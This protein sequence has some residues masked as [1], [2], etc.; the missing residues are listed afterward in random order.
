MISSVPVLC[1]SG[2]SDYSLLDCGHFRKLERF[3]NQVLI[4]PEPQAVWNPRWSEKDWKSNAHG[5]F[6]Q[7]SS[8][9]GEWASIKTLKE[10]WNIGYPLAHGKVTFRLALTGFKHVGIFPE[11]KV[12]WDFIF[13]NFYGKPSTFLNLFAYTGGASIVAKAAG[14]D[15]THVD[16]VRQVVS[17]ANENM[18]LS[19]LDDIRWTVE[20]ALKF[21]KREVRRGKKYTGIILD[22]PS[23]GIGAKGERWKLEDQINE[24][25]AETAIILEE[26][27]PIYILN[28]YSLGFSPLI[29]KNMMD[30]HFPSTPFQVAEIAQSAESGITLPLGV[31]AR[32]G[33][34]LNNLKQ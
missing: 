31:V 29:L 7:K 26:Q 21:V 6:I 34:D 12:N 18:K 16:S 17:W 30:D 10:R 22:P 3:G 5:E 2:W 23:Y 13:H 9:A 20:D 33:K 11:Q 1:S 27:N 15:V 28:C 19:G 8:Y 4:R 32:I 14:A 25:I 24:L